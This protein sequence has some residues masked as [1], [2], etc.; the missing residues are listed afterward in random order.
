LD[1]LDGLRAVIQQKWGQQALRPARQ[2]AAAVRLAAGIPALDALLGGGLP[3][4]ETSVFTGAPTSG[5]T[6]TAYHW[7]AAV[8]QMGEEVIYL[9]SSEVL[10][11]AYA[12]A[13]GV[14]LD[15]LL[16]VHPATLLAGLELV[17]EV[18]ASG[19]VGMV[20][21][22]AVRINAPLQRLRLQQMALLLLTTTPVETAAA[23][24]LH[25]RR[26]HWLTDDRDIVGCEVEAQLLK[27]P[28]QTHQV[29]RYPLYFPEADA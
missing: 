24:H 6:T 17:R 26:R 4:G 9:D 8:Q 13:C 1:T 5:K 19:V 21:L 28:T 25:F 14:D 23:V 16:I 10:D 3:R 22:D 7:L 29:A 12:A 2:V 20:V 15:R 11:P 18:A 27:H